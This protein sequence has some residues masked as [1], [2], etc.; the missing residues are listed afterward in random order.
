MIQSSA[1]GIFDSGLGGLT[2]FAAVKE[3]MPN[4]NIIYLGDTARVPYGDKSPETV[5]R[6]GYENAQFMIEKN[7]KLI[8]IACNT[9]SSL[10]ICG[11]RQYFTENNIKIPIIGVLEAGVEAVVQQNIANLA[12]IG[13]RATIN[14]NAYR[15]EL[16]KKANSISVRTIACPLF[17]LI[18]EEGLG[19]HKIANLA[20]D[21][22]LQELRTN[23][24]D[25]L[26]LGCTH[27]PLLIDALQK[28]LPENVKIIDSAHAVANLAEKYMSEHNLNNPITENGKEAFYVTDSPEIFAAQAEK[29]LGRALQN[30]QKTVIDNAGL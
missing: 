17:A 8:I 29:F 7:V 5:L 19:N 24:P 4:E 27:Y 30:V 9:V 26:L 13:T 2:V 18:A 1:I 20:I 12:V 16:R 28:Y 15:C 21:I 23:P 25:A 3:R 14:S 11:I 6:F 10:A 22:Y